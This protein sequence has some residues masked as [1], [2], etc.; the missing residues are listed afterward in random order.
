MLKSLE[1]FADN[2][3][4]LNTPSYRYLCRT[5]TSARLALADCLPRAFYSVGI[6][7][8]QQA[9]RS[10]PAPALGRQDLSTNA[11]GRL[12]QTDATLTDYG[13]GR[14]CRRAVPG[15]GQPPRRSRDV[16]G[17]R[18]TLDDAQF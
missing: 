18:L 6:Y 11:T 5:Q 2:L 17:R 7:T 15:F 16:H 13:F 3:T 4:L 10:R 9:A 14:G 12:S 8:L 1:H